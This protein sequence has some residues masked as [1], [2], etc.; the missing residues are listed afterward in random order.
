MR[1]I[2][3]DGKQIGV[4]KISDAQ[5]S[6]REEG[7]DLIEIA[8][9]AKPPVVRMMELGKF[10]YQEEKKARAEKK[11]TKASELKEVRFSPFIAENDFATRLGE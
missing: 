11:K 2:G 4:L 3:A 6:A 10:L 7:L 1:V 5:A 8:P 9:Q